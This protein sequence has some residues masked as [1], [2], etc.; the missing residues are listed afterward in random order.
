MQTQLTLQLIENKKKSLHFYNKNWLSNKAKTK[1]Y[2]YL[3]TLAS[4]LSFCFHQQSIA[5]VISYKSTTQ[6]P[7]QS[8]I[9]STTVTTDLTQVIHHNT[10]EIGAP[11]ILAT[12]ADITV[13]IGNNS[14]LSAEGPDGDDFRA[15]DIAI[16]HSEESK[17]LG[18]IPKAVINTYG[19]VQGIRV[20]GISETE[21]PVATPITIN[22]RAGKVYGSTFAIFVNQFRSTGDSSTT[23][24]INNAEVFNTS[25]NDAAIYVFGNQPTPDLVN[26]NI[27]ENAYL[28]SKSGSAFVTIGDA[29]INN[30]GRI[31]GTIRI[32]AIGKVNNYGQWL[33]GGNNQTTHES[34]ASEILNIGTLGL[35]PYH[36]SSQ[37][38]YKGN[39]TNTSL[40]KLSNGFAGDRVTIDGN[41]TSYNGSSISLDV[42]LGSDN[43]AKDQLIIT[44]DTYGESKIFINNIGGNGEQTVNGIQIIKVLGYSEGKFNLGAPVQAGNY[45]YLLYKVGNDFYLVSSLAVKP[46]EPNKQ[47]NANSGSGLES[48][49]SLNSYPSKAPQLLRPAVTGFSITPAVNFQSNYAMLGTTSSRAQAQSNAKKAFQ[50]V[51]AQTGFAKQNFASHAQSTHNPYLDTTHLKSH[52]ETS[53]L[54]IGSEL[55]SATNTQNKSS[56]TIQ[57]MAGASQTQAQI[58]N[59]DRAKAGLNSQTSELNSTETNIGL[60]HQYRFEDGMYVSATANIGQLSN[61]FT[62]VY[63]GSAKQKGTTFNVSLETSKPYQIANWT[64]EPQAQ[65]MFQQ[66]HLNAFNDAISNI[67]SLTTHN[68][69]LRAG[70]K[71]SRQN[72]VLKVSDFFTQIDLLQDHQSNK[73]IN[74]SHENINAKLDNQPWLGLTIGGTYHAGQ[75]QLKAQIGYEKSISGNGKNGFNIQLALNHSF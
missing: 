8:S 70:V 39:I 56:Q 63:G 21:E 5:Q 11:V 51:W 12:G 37:A 16:E 43:S 54:Q 49:G 72:A 47:S 28:Y 40:I 14:N 15:I 45:E 2:F 71:L 73:S 48:S 26:I 69:R 25:L 44:G 58:S 31:H 46:T 60:E 55:W 32:D 68:T 30:E 1:V 42:N 9:L 74:I 41:L 65:I 50:S 19:S 36:Q 35:L 4:C 7:T 67:E 75:S 66:L 23:I 22:I 34:S 61:S 10:T 59:P 18:I 38:I 24:N 17:A 57:L 33:V 29:T 13:H 62:D 6:T 20:A 64:L 27:G 3:S 52:Q 53:F